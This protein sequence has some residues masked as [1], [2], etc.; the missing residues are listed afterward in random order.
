M[1]CPYYCGLWTCLGTR[2]KKIL[3]EWLAIIQKFLFF[4]L[5]SL[6]KHFSING[7]FIA[8]VTECSIDGKL[9]CLTHWGWDKMA[10]IFQ[11][12][13]SN[14]FS[15][16]KMFKF[17]LIFRWILF[18]MVQLTVSQHWLRKGLGA[19]QATSH[20]L[21]QRWRSSLTHMHLS[22]SSS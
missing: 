22:A 15:L 9:L 4:L 3:A 6:S 11:T 21:N 14:A 19:D 1:W 13:F 18:L 8:E 10:A 17:R 7:D 20:Y 12:T 16:M 2:W 5:L